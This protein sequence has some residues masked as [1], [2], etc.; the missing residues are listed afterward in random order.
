[1][2]SGYV[3]IDNKAGRA[4]FYILTERSKDPDNAPLVLWLKCEFKRIC[5]DS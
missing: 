4:L 1:M 5:A 3:P 2:Y